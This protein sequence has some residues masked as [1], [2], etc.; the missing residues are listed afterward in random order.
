M[1]LT[2]RLLASVRKTTEAD[3]ACKRAELAK[4]LFGARL[5]KKEGGCFSKESSRSDALSLRSP[6]RCFQERIRS[7]H[8]LHLAQRDL[9]KLLQRNQLLRRHFTRFS[10]G[11]RRQV[12]V[13]IAFAI[14]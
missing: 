12:L 9:D 11:Q 13:P 7:A 1:L 4:C 3:S 10:V 14:P 6:A 5:T 2:F 8:A